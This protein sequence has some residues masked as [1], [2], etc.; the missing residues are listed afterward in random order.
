MSAPPEKKPHWPES[1][2]RFHE[3]FAD[4]E[5]VDGSLTIAINHRNQVRAGDDSR[6]T[7]PR[8]SALGGFFP[9]D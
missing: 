5:A 7:P 6:R 1:E 3:P 9:E 2:E 8:T 4:F